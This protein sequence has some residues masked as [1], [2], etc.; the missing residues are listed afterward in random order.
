MKKTIL[1]RNYSL[2]VLVLLILYLTYINIPDN[3]IMTGG[4]GENPYDRY[5][6]ER[7][8]KILMKS[9][10]VYSFLNNYWYLYIGINVIM[11]I[12]LAYFGYSQFLYQG[13][14][15]AGYES[16]LSWDTQGQIFL[17]NFYALAKTKYGLWTPS[18]VQQFAPNAKSAGL[19]TFQ[20]DAD[21]LVKE[22]KKAVD[23]FCHIVAPCNLCS[24]SGPDPN[25]AGPS[26]SAPTITYKGKNSFGVSCDAAEKNQLGTTSA[27][28]K[29]QEMQQKRGISN[30]FI[31][32]LPSCCCNLLVKSAKDSSGK[33]TS[34]SVDN[35][36]RD[37]PET[38]GLLGPGCDPVTTSLDVT[39]PDPAGGPSS[40][41]SVALHKDDNGNDTFMRDMISSCTSDKKS[42]DGVLSVK[43]F[44]INKCKDYD[45]ELDKGVSM[46]N[47]TKNNNLTKYF[48]PSMIN[49]PGPTNLME[50]H[51]D[52][53]SNPNP[54]APP[55]IHIEKPSSWPTTVPFSGENV[56]T[57]YYFINTNNI[58]YALTIDNHLYEVYAYPVKD[59]TKVKGSV[60]QITDQPSKSFLSDGILNYN[61]IINGAYVFP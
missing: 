6:D 29:I 27:A 36:I 16:Q 57:S 54:N 46:Y 55:R 44:Y 19:D 4:D 33:I 8:N 22:A 30:K 43:D 40:S 39:V 42:P 11:L 34:A 50:A 48:T 13:V 10:S 32:R 35:L 61:A 25:Y 41:R 31:G 3:L 52:W 38:L 21:Q 59:I 49:S 24:C 58:T 60:Q 17:T 51:S 9:S 37:P 15:I 2:L 18:T 20:H 1:N 56:E 12:A 5:S 47:V 26:A 14:P 23:A 28:A 7:L 53:T 45:P